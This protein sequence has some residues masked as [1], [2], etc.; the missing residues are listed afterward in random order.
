MRWSPPVALLPAGLLAC[1]APDYGM[2]T[3]R[4]PAAAPDV[5]VDLVIDVAWQDNNWGRDVTRCQVQ[6]AF[7][8]L[9][10]A[11]G[12]E[13]SGGGDS[14]P[15]G[16]IALPEAPGS[17]AVTV[18]Q[19]PG[20]PEEPGE[21]GHGDPDQRPHDE[22]GPDPHDEP[23]QPGDADD[24]WQVRGEVLGPETVSLT[25]GIRRLRLAGNA[26]EGGG[27]RYE[28]EG[29]DADSFPFA[30]TFALDV[31]SSPDP[32]GV[33]GFSMEDLVSVGPRLHLD[34]P[35]QDEHSG[36]PVVTPS[37]DLA[38]RWSFDGPDPVVDGEPLPPTTLVKLFVQDTTRE[39]GDRWLICAAEEEGWLDV[40][41]AALAELYADMDDP[42]A[43]RTSLD[44]HSEV[45][46]RAQ[47]TP[48]GELLEVRAHVSSGAPLEHRV[49]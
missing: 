35:A 42:S 43:W 4:T 11:P 7:E 16:G 47:E 19:P 34:A 45:A 31:D 6:V 46:G 9:Q 29:C 8:P 49:E 32:D 13:P 12:A 18:L 44:V 5:P 41:A 15:G 3:T 30:A 26:V 40:P 25:D 39:R 10:L 36:F 2:S 17:C 22:Q 21:G 33:H 24:D 27:L 1:G 14:P 28:L 48:W 23:V 20:Q 38:V 37:E